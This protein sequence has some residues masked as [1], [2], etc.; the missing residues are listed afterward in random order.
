MT[1]FF[2]ILA[3]NSVLIYVKNYEE[4]NKP[5]SMY[6]TLF[7]LKAKCFWTFEST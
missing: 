2:K 6:K 1:W 4:L 3:P 7:F 5:Q